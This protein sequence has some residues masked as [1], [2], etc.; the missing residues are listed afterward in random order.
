MS[1]TNSK[2][3]EAYLRNIW[4]N[5]EHQERVYVVFLNSE[6][7]RLDYKRIDKGKLNTCDVNFALIVKTALNKKYHFMVLAHNHPVGDAKPSSFDLKVTDELVNVLRFLDITLIDHIILTKQ[8]YFSFKDAGL[9][10]SK[11]AKAG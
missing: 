7:I 9:V 4:K 10:P 2:E 8:E 5:I 1:L 3:C 11:F 6:G